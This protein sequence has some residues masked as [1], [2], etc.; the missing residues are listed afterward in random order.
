MVIKRLLP[1]FE[2]FAPQ[3]AAELRVAMNAIATQSDVAQG[4]GNRAIDRGIAPDD[5]SGDP[6]KSLQDRIDHAKT[7]EERDGI[8]A[9]TAAAIAGKG[10]PQSHELANKIEAPEFRKQT[11]A[12]VDFELLRA[13]FQKKDAA[14][15]IRITRTGELTRIQRVW[16]YTQAGR[17]TSDQARAIDL[18]QE[19]AAESRRMEGSDPDRARGLVAVANGFAKFDHA[20]SWEFMTE[21]VKAANGA[22]TF[23]GEDGQVSAMLRSK[24]FGMATA[25]ASNDFNVADVFG[26]LATEDFYRSVALA[27]NFSGDIPRANAT[28]AVARAI[29]EPKRTGQTSAP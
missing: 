3:Q 1:L 25:A 9:D 6:I 29:L 13:A 19:A 26:S 12:Y 2:Q 4:E 21:A 23:T 5:P 14:E 11:L 22:E 24:N 16:G 15:I 7:S 28:I 18:L 10:D 8:Y 17:F 20:R 27:K